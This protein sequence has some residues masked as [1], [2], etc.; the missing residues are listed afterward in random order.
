MICFDSKKTVEILKDML[1]LVYEAW[2][3]K[4]VFLPLKIENKHHYYETIDHEINFKNTGFRSEQDISILFSHFPMLK[5][6]MEAIE[7]PLYASKVFPN[8]KIQSWYFDSR[9]NLDRRQKGYIHNIRNG[10][11]SEPT[12]YFLENYDLMLTRSSTI[13]RM[14]S[15]IP[16]VLNSCKKSVNIQ[17]NNHK[18][19]IG[20]GEDY[21]FSH[22][23]FYA[24][25]GRKFTDQSKSLMNKKGF[26]KKKI[27]AFVGSVCWW[28]G[29][30]EWFESV[31]STLLKDYVVVILGPSKDKNY[32]N[33]I[34]KAA[35]DKSVSVLY[36]DYVHPDFLC[37][38]LTHCKI[39][40]MNPF[41]EP[42]WQLSLGP[43]RT[44]GESI[45]CHNICVHGLSK[46]PV[47]G[48]NG[49]TVSLP[50]SWKD[51]IIEFD[52]TDRNS[53][54]ESLEKAINSNESDIDFSTQI[55]FEEKCDDIFQKCLNLM[56]EKR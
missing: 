43:A 29:Q 27:I 56:K 21:A 13:N 49:K 33:R 38:F 25:A 6:E 9:G 53:Y 24:P 55:T 41:M 40:I 32:L 42:P 18:Q 8:S 44:V 1:P 37:D 46:D 15:E 17:T 11:T 22:D 50:E 54:N 36:S 4:D 2:K 35:E 45:A 52:N 16:Q 39:S 47:N 3:E 31:D 7:M 48:I 10:S 28:K 20:I 19:C 12:G 5:Y 26:E 23:D 34:K 30:A 51:Y 14:K